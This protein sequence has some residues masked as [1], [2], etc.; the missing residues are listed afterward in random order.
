MEPENNKPQRRPLGGPNALIVTALICLIFFGQAVGSLTDAVF[1]GGIV[2]LLI[3][4]GYRL[5]CFIRDHGD[6]IGE[7]RFDTRNDRD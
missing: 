7:A 4:G 2:I 5:H 6:E 1:L 3:Y